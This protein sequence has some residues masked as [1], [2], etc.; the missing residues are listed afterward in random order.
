MVFDYL[1]TAQTKHR[2]ILANTWL[3][4]PYRTNIFLS[5]EKSHNFLQ[6]LPIEE[7]LKYFAN[8]V[9]TFSILSLL[10]QDAMITIPFTTGIYIEVDGRLEYVSWVAELIRRWNRFPVLGDD[11]CGVRFPTVANFFVL[12]SIFNKNKFLFLSRFIHSPN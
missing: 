5:W 1:Y 11:R 4:T 12:P 7:K 3:G 8:C 10:V 2:R 6:F 9:V